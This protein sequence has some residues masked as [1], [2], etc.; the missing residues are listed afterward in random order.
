MDKKLCIMCKH[1]KSLSKFKKILTNMSWTYSSVCLDCCGELGKNESKYYKRT[2]KVL[3]K[4]EK[5]E[6]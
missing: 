4:Y 5:I 2:R 3:K 1:P 6:F